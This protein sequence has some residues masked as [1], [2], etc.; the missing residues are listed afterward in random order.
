M[1]VHL[2]KD[3]SGAAMLTVVIAILFIVALGV[4]LL[5]ASYV[6]YAVTL[7]QEKSK[8]NLYDAEAAMD[9]IRTGIHNAASNALAD[10]YTDTLR[11]Y[12]KDNTLDPQTVFAN[13]FVNNLLTAKYGLVAQNAASGTYSAKALAAF[14][15]G[16]KASTLTVKSISAADASAGSG[17]IVC[18]PVYDAKNSVAYTSFT[19]KNVKLV[20]IDKKNYETDISTDI[21]ISVPSF[22][23]SASTPHTAKEYS[24][25]A[26]A[27][28]S[29]GAASQITGNVFAGGIDVSTGGAALTFTGGDVISSGDVAVGKLA[30]K[31]VADG[32][33]DRFQPD[34]PRYGGKAAE[35]RH[36][37]HR[38]AD[39]PKRQIGGGDGAQPFGTVRRDEIGQPEI[40]EA[41]AGIDQD[42]AVRLQSG[43]DI[44][45]MQQRRILDDQ[46]V[47]RHDRL[48][49]AD[50]PVSD[51]TERHHR[52]A[53]T[54]R[55]E[56]GKGLRMP[57]FLEG[58][59]RQH[60][61]GGN[62]ALTAASVYS[63]L[64]HCLLLLFQGYVSCRPLR[65][66]SG[67][68]VLRNVNL[69][70]TM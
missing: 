48:A 54:L 27:G 22:K 36:V 10:A 13:K 21:C 51:T 19:L 61:G 55:T 14:A 5:S 17:E 15:D 65:R 63:H 69:C 16:T 35:Q 33:D 43:E 67:N 68:P 26:N 64:E 41:L 46:C 57:P 56:T 47:G 70:F 40:R 66:Y 31:Y 53:G 3:N 52:R 28:L 2:K 4:A 39:M 30:R 34:D 24:I 58:G 25:I 62:H 20:F 6:G 59:D 11:E 50:F 44:D 18:T 9:D 37:R 1:K 29:A 32:L 45:L 7:T 23:I 12:A 60:L 38:P 42:V 49:Q 8:A